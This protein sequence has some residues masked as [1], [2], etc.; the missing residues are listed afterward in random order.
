[1]GYLLTGLGTANVMGIS[2][3][4]LHALN[5][6]VAKGIMFMIAG[7][8]ILSTGAY[9][10][11][12]YKGLGRQ[13]PVIGI[14]LVIGL[15][16]LASIPFTGGFWSKLQLILGLFENGYPI[17]VFAGVSLLGLTF[18]AAAG[19]LWI[20]KYIVMDHPD[21]DTKNAQNIKSLS[22]RK[23]GF[24]KL[25]IVILTLFVVILGLLPGPFANFTIQAANFLLG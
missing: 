13:D 3:V 4:L 11:D 8:L 24:M 10:L 9:Y 14:C 25:A 7:Y 17:G 12:Q 2:G 23:S 21:M 1:M 20:I 15:F 18:F 19:Y 22:F 5:H 16:S 6:A